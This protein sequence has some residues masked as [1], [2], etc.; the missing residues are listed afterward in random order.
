MDVG[1]GH[2]DRG[3]EDRGRED[4]GEGG[5]RRAV[6][7]QAGNVWAHEALT[8]P[9]GLPVARS[10]RGAGQ[11]ARHPKSIPARTGF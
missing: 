2:E 8:C 9:S 1:R 5:P 4:R 3:P 6:A 10:Q 11:R 7:K